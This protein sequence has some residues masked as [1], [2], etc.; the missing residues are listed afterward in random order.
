MKKKKMVI[1]IICAILLICAVGIFLTTRNSVKYGL[2]EGTYSSEFDS[3]QI[4]FD[5][6]DDGSISFVYKI[7]GQV[8]MQ[9]GANIERGNVVL[10]PD[11]TEDV[12]TFEIIDNDYIGLVAKKSSNLY[13]DDGIALFENG[14]TFKFS[15]ER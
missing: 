8:T 6:K 3:S 15:D 12:Y 10:T 14:A 5:I 9:G 13:M 2:S 1:G 7:N 11:K 4:T